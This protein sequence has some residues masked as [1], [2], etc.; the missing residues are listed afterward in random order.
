MA[1][2]YWSPQAI[3]LRQEIFDYIALDSPQAAVRLDQRFS[4]AAEHLERFPMLGRPGR[5]VGT[6]EFIPHPSYRLI[7]EISDRGIEILIV[8]HAARMWPPVDPD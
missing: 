3:A 1:K 7:Y 8:I 4:D 2:A 5:L 6:R